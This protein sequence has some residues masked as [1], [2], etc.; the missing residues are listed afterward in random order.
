MGQVDTLD[1]QM[2]LSVIVD[3]EPPEDE[4][5]RLPFY[6]DLWAHWAPWS[7]RTGPAGLAIYSPTPLL[8]LLFGE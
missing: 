1:S 2:P 5:T 3:A 8:A 4:G 7:A 6:H